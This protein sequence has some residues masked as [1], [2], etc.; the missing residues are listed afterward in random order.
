M[1]LPSSN[2]KDYSIVKLLFDCA[3]SFVGVSENS[4]IFNPTNSS[5][6]N[7]ATW[8]YSKFQY[9]GSGTIMERCG[10]TQLNTDIIFSFLTSDDFVNIPFPEKYEARGKRFP[11]GYLM[12]L[13]DKEDALRD[14]KE[15]VLEAYSKLLARYM[16]GENIFSI[17]CSTPSFK[18]EIKPFFMKTSKNRMDTEDDF[19]DFIV[20]CQNEK[21]SYKANLI[22]NL[23]NAL[24]VHITTIGIRN[25]NERETFKVLN[26]KS[27]A[28]VKRIS[29]NNVDF[30]HFDLTEEIDPDDV[31]NVNLINAVADTFD[32]S[33]SVWGVKGRSPLT[34]L[35]EE[36]NSSNEEALIKDLDSL[37][38]EVYDINANNLTTARNMK[39][40]IFIDRYIGTD[41]TNLT[42]TEIKKL[43]DN[44]E[45]LN[46]TRNFSGLHTYDVLTAFNIFLQESNN[47]QSEQR[48]F[49][50]SSLI[51]DTEKMKS[52]IP[53]YFFDS[54]DGIQ[55]IKSKRVK[56]SAFASAYGV[57]KAASDIAS[58][59]N[60]NSSKQY[61]GLR[62]FNS[63]CWDDSKPFSF[64]EDSDANRFSISGSPQTYLLIPDLRYARMFIKRIKAFSSLN[65]IKRF[66]GNTPGITMSDLIV[67]S[68]EELNIMKN[69]QHF[70]ALERIHKCNSNKHKY[71]SEPFSDAVIC[72]EFSNK[73]TMKA[74]LDLIN[75]TEIHTFESSNKE[76][77]LL[78]TDSTYHDPNV[79]KKS[80]Q[81]I[82]KMF[83]AHFKLMTHI[84]PVSVLNFIC[85]PLTPATFVPCLERLH[86]DVY[87]VYA[88]EYGKTYAEGLINWMC[89]NQKDNTDMIPI[90]ERYGTHN[91]SSDK[92]KDSSMVSKSDA[93]SSLIL[94]EFNPNS[95]QYRGVEYPEDAYSNLHSFVKDIVDHSA[96]SNFEDEP[97][98]YLGELSSL[99]FSSDL[100]F[101]KVFIN[102]LSKYFFRKYK[103]ASSALTVN[104]KSIYKFRHITE[105]TTNNFG[106][107]VMIGAQITSD[108]FS[109][110]VSYKEKSSKHS[111]IYAELSS[112]RSFYDFLQSTSSNQTSVDIQNGDNEGKGSAAIEPDFFK[113]TLLFV[114]TKHYERVLYNYLIYLFISKFKGTNSGPY[115]PDANKTNLTPFRIRDFLLAEM[116]SIQS[117]DALYVH[118]IMTAVTHCTSLEELERILYNI[119]YFIAD[120]FSS[121]EVNNRYA[122][123]NKHFELPLYP[124]DVAKDLLNVLCVCSEIM[125]N[126]NKTRHICPEHLL[127]YVDKVRAT[128]PELLI[129]VTND[130]RPEFLELLLNGTKTLLGIEKSK[131]FSNLFG[132]EPN[133]LFSLCEASS[134]FTQGTNIFLKVPLSSLNGKQPAEINEITKNVNDYFMCDIKNLKD[135]FSSRS[136]APRTRTGGDLLYMNIP[137]RMKKLLSTLEGLSS[138]T[139]LDTKLCDCYMQVVPKMFYILRH[140]GY[141]VNYILSARTIT[142]D[143]AEYQINPFLYNSYLCHR[144]PLVK[145]QFRLIS[146]LALGRD[147]MSVM[148]KVLSSSTELSLD[149]QSDKSSFNELVSKINDFIP[150]L[151]CEE[152]YGPQW[153]TLVAELFINGIP[154][155][156]IEDL[157]EYIKTNFDM[158]DLE[159]SK[160][161]GILN[162]NEF[163]S[164]EIIGMRPQEMVS[165]INNVNY[166]YD[167]N[168]SMSI[169][170]E[171]SIRKRLP[172]FKDKVFINGIACVD[173]KPFVLRFGDAWYLLLKGGDIVKVGEEE[174]K[175]DSLYTNI[176]NISVAVRDF[177]GAEQILRLP[178]T[179][180]ITQ[181]YSTQTI[182]LNTNVPLNDVMS[183]RLEQL[184]EE[185]SALNTYESTGKLPQSE[186]QTLLLE[187]SKKNEYTQSTE[188]VMQNVNT[189]LANVS[190]QK[191]SI[192]AKQAE[193]QSA[194]LTTQQ[195]IFLNNTVVR[196]TD[197]GYKLTLV[198]AKVKNICIKLF[199]F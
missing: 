134:K 164:D 109:E 43:N 22:D 167:S 143:N 11:A 76:G 198:G 197:D 7:I 129:P 103:D 131:A 6:Y 42:G 72:P 98:Y 48:L 122:A 127:K 55:D 37:F 187:N 77:F 186:E 157:N 85:S 179:D 70:N 176:K 65:R 94:N 39:I 112:Y 138:I 47:A 71:H 173:D 23:V 142:T 119:G 13:P 97:I 169:D 190:K 84:D 165:L 46:N 38:H 183:P 147:R 158:C 45:I 87:S 9:L 161:L 180:K 132:E 95:L 12:N 141:D 152:D 26:R 80:Q 60:Q 69:S 104:P 92:V 185:W 81:K 100:G 50:G 63:D 135:D 184:A 14:I 10:V 49:S 24:V 166:I 114:N 133:S 151:L 106:A 19:N 153:K 149:V 54:Y 154:K 144:Y 52:S 115:I 3:L 79:F 53:K 181:N 125:F 29:G 107:L 30:R 120:N 28:P 83:D 18:T 67:R 137:G 27:L 148:Q 73:R 56:V 136:S 159:F 188:L 41:R 160:Q 128:H 189:S 1:L 78:R 61:F 145:K 117:K 16:A 139:E 150:D 57:A 34:T 32:F 155:S 59:A 175:H 140:I 86:G 168:N 93:F 40:S 20:A 89:F 108:I 174:S 35:L 105:D 191:Y 8:W 171:K 25:N 75:K 64:S 44:K 123:A 74:I 99:K 193:Q 96:F 82:Y 113:K 192:V 90:I 163:L 124:L 177:K 170:M 194:D 15:K 66:I 146:T 4:D 110:I 102:T 178:V 5:G 88:S 31:S 118:H 62:D 126:K 33:Q 2:L 58:G 156:D 68:S 172:I 116:R 51:V 21:Y 101:F 195:S 36:E 182:N 130:T 162:K 199:E 17:G 91:I 111:S 196:K 121:G